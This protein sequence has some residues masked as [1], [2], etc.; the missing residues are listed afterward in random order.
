MLG[1]ISNRHTSE[2]LIRSGLKWEKKNNV[3]FEGLNRFGLLTCHEK[4]QA[5]V[6]IFEVTDNF[7]GKNA[8][9]SKI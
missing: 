7:T 8:G 9:V 4:L 3:C 2:K 6:W 1:P 5:R